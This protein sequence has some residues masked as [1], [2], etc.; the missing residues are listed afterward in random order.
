M[1]KTN[2]IYSFV[3]NKLLIFWCDKLEC[4]FL[5]NISIVEITLNVDCCPSDS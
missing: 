4:I 1:T 2:N 3:E 5:R